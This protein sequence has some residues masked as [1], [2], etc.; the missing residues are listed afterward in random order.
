MLKKRLIAV[1]IVNGKYVVQSVKFKHTNAIHY[2]AAEAIECF[3]KW[4]IDE[5]II[6]NVSRN[7]ETRMEFGKTIENICK[8]CFLPVAVGGWITDINYARELFYKG[9]DKLILNTAFH[10]KPAL[11]ESLASKFGTQ[12]ITASIDVKE[13]NKK[14]TVWVDR[15]RINTKHCPSYWAKRTVELGAGEIFFNSIDHDG[16]RKGYNLLT[17]SDI[18]SSVNVPVI[19]FGGV[20][21][22]SHLSEG[23]REGADAVALANQLH[24]TEHSARRAKK[25]LINEGLNVRNI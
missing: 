18:S 16:A 6:L 4:S 15:G 23:I 10:S 7:E 19:A 21:N 9:A 5:I 20:F 25:F 1:L 3:N 12:S 11:C 2:D 24:Y 13:E 14:T 22:W 8:K 17:L